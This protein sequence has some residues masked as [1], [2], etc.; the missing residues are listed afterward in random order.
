MTTLTDSSPIEL[1]TARHALFAAPFGLDEL[2]EQRPVCPLRY[3]DGH[4]GWLVTSYAAARAVLMDSRFSMQP[5]REPYPNTVPFAVILEATDGAPDRS[6]TLLHLDPPEHTRLRRMQTGHFSVQQVLRHRELVERAASTCLDELE[7]AGSPADLVERFTRPLPAIVLCH[8]LGIPETDRGTFERF[9]AAEDDSESSAE[10]QIEAFQEF[11]DYCKD[12][13]RC[14]RAEPADDVL[15]GLVASGVADEDELVDTVATLVT[16]GHDTTLNLLALSTLALLVDRRRWESLQADPAKIETAVE[17]FVRYMTIFPNTFTRTAV[18]DVE[19]DGTVIKAGQS[20]TISLVAANR[21]P[22]KFERPE[23]LQL[24]RDATGHLGFGQ[25]RHMCLG[26]H[27]AR[28][29]MRVGLTALMIR[30]PT[31]E[32]AVPASEI[33]LHRSEHVIYGVK[34]LPVCW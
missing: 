6:G 5:L 14:K 17:E 23:E 1:P 21:D 34:S 20:V 15:S 10:A 19:L 12:V 31:L 8:V 26:Q 4:V 32:L 25:G 30:F 27:L 28:L 22:A 18:E 9:T 11:R 3:P 29:E 7:A 33:P 13:L 2:R 16:A 24:T